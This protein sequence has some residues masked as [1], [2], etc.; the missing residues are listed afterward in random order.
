[1]LIT[2]GLKIDINN[3]MFEHQSRKILEIKNTMK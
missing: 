1:M 3:Y 2:F